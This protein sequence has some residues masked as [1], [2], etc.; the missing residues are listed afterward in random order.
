[1]KRMGRGGSQGASRCPGKRAD[2]RRNGEHDLVKYILKLRF[3]SSK[4]PDVAAWP[5]Q[6]QG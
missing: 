5:K 4:L 6:G 1:M 2:L 3:I